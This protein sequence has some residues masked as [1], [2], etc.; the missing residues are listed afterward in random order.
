[1]ARRELGKDF[2]SEILFPRR[3]IFSREKSR[4]A[5]KFR[6]PVDTSI[7]VEEQKRRQMEIK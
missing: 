4:V 5:D 2:R 7:T 1:M 3:K 6:I